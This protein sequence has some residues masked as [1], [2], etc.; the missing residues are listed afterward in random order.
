MKILIDARPLTDPSSGGVGRVAREL[1]QAYA[2]AFPDDEL[3]CATTGASR[4]VLPGALAI[5][6]NIRHVHLNVPNKVWSARCLTGDSFVRAIERTCG[7]FDAVFFPNIGFIGRRGTRNSVLLLHDLSFLIEPRWFTRKQRLWHHV[8][9]ARQLI[10][11]STHLLAV[12]ETTKRDTI[13]L[14]GIPAD[15]VSVIPIGQT[16]SAVPR[17]H[18]PTP[19]RFILALGGNGPR[20]NVAT[21]KV[22]V[23][24]LRK[25]PQYADVALVIPTDKPSDDELAALYANAAAFLYPSWYEGYGLPLHEAAAYG[26]PCVASTAGALPETAPAGTLFANPAKPH[27]WVEALKLALAHTRIPI[28]TDPDTWIRAATQ[29][30][31]SFEKAQD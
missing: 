25:D 13:R 29:L 24:Q 31:G 4:P 3:T 10:R 1:V 27:H 12:S 21:A 23:D 26:T 20:K 14:L 18:I 16:L 6:P 28:Q 19:Q 11:K 7:V 30:R 8:V 22:A 5:L 9:N 17:A 15:R 2:T